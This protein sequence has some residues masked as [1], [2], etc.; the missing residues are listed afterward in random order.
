[1]VQ[2]ALKFDKTDAM[3]LRFRR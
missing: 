1:M 2:S 3:I